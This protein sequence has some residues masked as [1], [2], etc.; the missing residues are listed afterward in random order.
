LKIRAKA[1]AESGKSDDKYELAKVWAE[2]AELGAI[3]KHPKVNA[4]SKHCHSQTP[5][6]R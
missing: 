4:A 2:D 6:E 1:C 3:I 5:A